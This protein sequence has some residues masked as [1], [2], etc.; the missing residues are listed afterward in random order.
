MIDTKARFLSGE[1]IPDSLLPQVIARSWQRCVDRKVSIDRKARE[2]PVVSSSALKGFRERSKQLIAHSEPVMAQLHQQISGTSS[3]VV[4]TDA[5]G[6]VLH[7]V[8][9]PD[10]QAKAQ[11]VTLQPGG[12]WTEE[13]NGTNAIG[14]ALIEK[15]PVS[16]QSGEHFIEINQFLTCSAAPIFDPHGRML[17]VLDVS[18][19]S[20]AFQRHT[21]AL[22]RMAAQTI[23]N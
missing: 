8:G 4:L 16:V 18:S 17:G 11:M 5:A 9:D 14:T 2:I 6:V 15:I 12:L 21:M 19:D 3:V 13:A 7:S 20:A 10:F 22:V 23:E 1:S